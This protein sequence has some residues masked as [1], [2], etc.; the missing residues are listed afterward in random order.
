MELA[1]NNAIIVLSG[2]MRLTQ[3]Q[4]VHDFNLKRPGR[5]VKKGKGDII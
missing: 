4:V 1:V 3:R 2:D 5:E